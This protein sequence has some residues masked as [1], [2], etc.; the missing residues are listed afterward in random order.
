MKFRKNQADVPNAQNQIQLFPILLINFIGTIAKMIRNAI[1]VCN[2]NRDSP[3]N[4]LLQDILDKIERRK[5][6]LYEVMQ[7]SK[8]VE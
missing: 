7:R 8:N 3:T 5:W 1:T 4:N 2:E 6:F